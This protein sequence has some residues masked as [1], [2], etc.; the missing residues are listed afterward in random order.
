MNADISTLKSLL[1]K[2]LYLDNLNEMIE[3]CNRI[4]AQVAEPL[5]V[6]V[7]LSIFYDIY[8]SWDERFLPV[9]EIKQTESLFLPSLK[10]IITLIET[11]DDKSKLW[12][13]LNDLT[14]AYVSWVKREM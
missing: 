4:I 10:G 7:L 9:E 5:P 8:L 6:Y 1:S 11:S 12:N 3:I 13:A 14:K 2:G